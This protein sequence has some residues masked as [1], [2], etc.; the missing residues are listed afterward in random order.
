MSDE[1]KLTEAEANTE[2]QPAAESQ[3]EEDTP[4]PRR[5]SGGERTAGGGR[6]GCR[7]CG[8]GCRR[9]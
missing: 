8:R 9:V 2:E 6:S 1:T 7:A 5:E 4:A 3:T